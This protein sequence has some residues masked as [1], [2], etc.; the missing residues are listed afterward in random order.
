MQL[1]EVYDIIRETQQKLH[2]EHAMS[3][4]LDE[5]Y[6]HKL[7]DQFNN[8]FHGQ[9]AI[10]KH[11][12][13]RIFFLI[14]FSQQNEIPI[15]SKSFNIKEI[16][17]KEVKISS[18]FSTDE[19]EQNNSNLSMTLMDLSTKGALTPLLI[20]YISFNIIPSL[21]LMFLESDH[22]DKFCNF[23][24]KIKKEDKNNY[25][26]YLFSRSLF[27]SPMFLKFFRQSTYPIFNPIYNGHLP[28]NFCD[29]IKNIQIKIQKDLL[30]SF[31][32]N[33]CFIP[34]YIKIF[35]NQM[36]DTQ[37][38]LTECLFKPFF[39]NPDIYLVVD[40][41]ITDFEDKMNSLKDLLKSVFSTDFIKEISKIID[42][43]PDSEKTLFIQKNDTS[44][45]T[46]SL[47]KKIINS[48]DQI[49]LEKMKNFLEDNNPK[50]IDI[51]GNLIIDKY[52]IYASLFEDEENDHNAKIYQATQVGID[53]CWMQFRKLLKESSPL[54]LNYVLPDE[55]VNSESFVNLIKELMFY[56][57]DPYSAINAETSFNLFI[58]AFTNVRDKNIVSSRQ[59]FKAK[60]QSLVKSHREQSVAMKQMSLFK[61]ELFLLSTKKIDTIHLIQELYNTK[62]TYSVQTPDEQES[63]PTKPF[64]ILSNIKQ[65]N[66]D[67]QQYRRSQSGKIAQLLNVDCTEILFRR[68]FNPIKFNQ[69][70]SYRRDLYKYD[71]ATHEAF[72]QFIINLHP[73]NETDTYHKHVIK[74]AKH[75]EFFTDL[76][77]ELNKAFEA[78]TDPI[79]KLNDINK[80][81]NLILTHFADKFCPDAGE[82]DFQSLRNIIIS[83]ANPPRFVSN[84]IYLLEF[85]YDPSNPSYSDENFYR[86]IGGYEVIV[87]E[88]KNEI[89]HHNP[90]YSLARTHQ[91][92]IQLFFTG[93]DPDLL[94][95]TFNYF[96][97]LT[98]AKEELIKEDANALIGKIQSQPNI[99]FC[100]KARYFSNTDDNTDNKAHAF[101]N[102]LLLDG[103]IGK[104]IEFD[105][106]EG[107]KIGIFVYKHNPTSGLA[108]FFQRNPPEVRN[109]L[110]SRIPNSCKIFLFDQDEIS[111]DDLN[112]RNNITIVPRIQFREVIKNLLVS[113][114]EGKVII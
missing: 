96:V 29:L 102:C 67:F 56:T 46:K 8:S 48:V 11:Y 32:K 93:N 21:Y 84:V 36:K 38:I 111:V 114:D 9:M 20:D 7:I 60:M 12:F 85:L 54:P 15:D 6:N 26:H 88:A 62:L 68:F 57:N 95:E 101:V 76:I 105:Q 106:T 35:L 30:Q 37:K 66:S 1:K 112:I 110:N 10:D 90:I 39:E 34:S 113:F 13:S 59:D 86:I 41:S 97:G 109:F 65:I 81:M 53:N 73:E 91:K 80:A 74:A 79:T 83:Y 63:L 4:E 92:P 44:K 52:E 40:A 103:I 94:V 14:Y 50:Q 3:A 23:I 31:R 2:S 45:P 58:S 5:V 72:Q 107:N 24:A 47:Y 18:L 42:E 89:F 25:L 33:V 17:R 69:F 82:D 43:N 61:S 19:D 108:R 70:C 99:P 64:V 51:F 55:K 78:D 27:V 87:K 71:Q 98:R 75:I 104:D 22:F 77:T 49:V 28:P 100:I 16:S